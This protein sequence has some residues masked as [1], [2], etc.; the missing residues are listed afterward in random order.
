M[1]L[2]L[3]IKGLIAM[4]IVGIKKDCKLSTVKCLRRREKKTQNPRIDFP[5]RVLGCGWS[6][7]SLTNNVLL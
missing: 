3:A 4:V 6:H 7:N 2:Y 5:R 1:I